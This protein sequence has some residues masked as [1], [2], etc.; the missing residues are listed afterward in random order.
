MHRDFTGKK[1]KPKDMVR[2]RKL[3]TISRKGTK[4]R[5][6]QRSRGAV[7]LLGSVNCG[8]VNI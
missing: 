7:G 2:L 6:R 5:S 1:M 8:K 3:C 4:L